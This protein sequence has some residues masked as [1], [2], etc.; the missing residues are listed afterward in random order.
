VSLDRF[1]PLSPKNAPFEKT[2]SDVVQSTERFALHAERFLPHRAQP[3]A[4]N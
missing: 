2:S 3:I 1:L 4:E